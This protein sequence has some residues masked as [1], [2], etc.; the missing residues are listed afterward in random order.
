MK[1][2]IYVNDIKSSFIGNEIRWYLDNNYKVNIVSIDPVDLSEFSGSKI[3]NFAISYKEYSAFKT[4]LNDSFLV[5]KILL[6]EFISGYFLFSF[7]QIRLRVSTLLRSFFIASQLG[8][9]I[10]QNDSIHFSYWLDEWVLVLSI[11]KKR[12]LIHNCYSRAHKIDLYDVVENLKNDLPF[13]KFKL[14][15]V[16]KVYCCSK[17]G[18]NYLKNK[19][20]SFSESITYAYLG[21]F[22]NGLKSPIPT[23]KVLKI[24]SI[25]YLNSVKRIHLIV[26]TLAKLSRDVSW[27]HIGGGPLFESIF[28]DSQSLNSNIKCNLLGDLSQT[29][30]HLFFQK[31]EIDFLIN[32]SNDEGLPVSM[33]ESISYGVPIIG[34]D[35][36]GVKEIVND[37]TGILI[38][39]NFGTDLLASLLED[40]DDAKFRG[41]NY[42]KA[43]INF[44]E[45]NFDANQ[46]YSQFLNAHI[47]NE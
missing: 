42:R 19:Y 16:S 46:N 8:E 47:T 44:W 27:T 23:D 7:G 1:V 35:V 36:G 18:M 14:K 31:N 20:P 25:G 4:L 29:E 32:T 30:V 24:L 12:K 22:N 9:I 41:S 34:T 43:I 10:S 28:N 5:L 15:N 33:M 2:Y 21:T 13:L 6:F 17:S 45:F 3:E 26:E 40:L 11:L 38:E 39:K 37:K